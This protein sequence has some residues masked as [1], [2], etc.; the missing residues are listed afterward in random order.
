MGDGDGDALAGDVDAVIAEARC[1]GDDR[2]R[3]D[4][5]H[6]IDALEAKHCLAKDLSVEEALDVMFVRT[7]FDSYLTFVDDLGW[8]V[9]DYTQWLARMLSLCLLAP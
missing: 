3:A 2:K 7:S 4:L 1:C 8:S 6:V 5:R 9:E